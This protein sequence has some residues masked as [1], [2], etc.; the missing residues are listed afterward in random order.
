MLSKGLIVLLLS[1]VASADES[2]HWKDTRWV[3][4]TEAVLPAPIRLTA[5]TNTELLT[6]ATQLRAVVLCDDA[7]AQGKKST[8]VRCKFESNQVHVGQRVDDRMVIQ[9]VTQGVATVSIPYQAWE[10]N[11]GTKVARE[12]SQDVNLEGGGGL[13][14][15]DGDTST[16]ISGGKLQNNGAQAVS[17]TPE[18]RVF[19]GNLQSITI[20]DESNGTML[21]RLWTVVGQS[22]ANS[23]G[24]TQGVN[25][26]YNGHLRRLGPAEEI[27]IGTSVLVHQP[28][29]AIEGL[30]AWTPLNG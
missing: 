13:S 29:T 23:I 17:S 12:L 28:E 10:L 21:E 6:K 15:P 22:T 3:L 30:D 4:E 25:V 20:I 18:A 24:S 19:L 14:T 9:T 5:V 26:W 27:D 11:S 16:T 2:A 7:E 1:G 8:V